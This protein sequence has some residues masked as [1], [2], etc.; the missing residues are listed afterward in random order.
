MVGW[1]VCVGMFLSWLVHLFVILF[2]LFVVLYIWLVGLCWYVSFLVGWL[3]CLIVWF[4]L[5]LIT[6]RDGAEYIL[7]R[8]ES[9]HHGLRIFYGG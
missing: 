5:F 3:V 7:T 4:G 6:P 1:F 9:V 8:N 2:S